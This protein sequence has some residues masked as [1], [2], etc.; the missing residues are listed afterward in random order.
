MKQIILVGM[1]SVALASGC[2]PH[3]MKKK[4]SELAYPGYLDVGA[5]Y[6]VIP[7]GAPKSQDIG[8]FT[9]TIKA[10]PGGRWYAP[11][12]PKTEE[13]K[14]EAIN[15]AAEA[16]VA[17][18]KA[19]A[20]QKEA[21]VAKATNEADATQKET[22]AGE[23]KNDATAKSNEYLLALKAIADTSIGAEL[24]QIKES[25]FA[26]RVFIFY[27]RSIGGYG[28]AVNGEVDAIGLGYDVTP[29]FALIAGQARYSVDIPAV[30]TTA[31]ST[32][33]HDGL[34]MGVQL[35]LNAFQLFRALGKTD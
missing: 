7:Y 25:S 29:E 2:T 35:N 8:G 24:Y 34:M 30:G 13:Q 5:G 32:D 15:K 23:A 6:T 31:A 22:D 27:G 20:I 4:H 9:A 1:V 17:K 19:N 3:Y 16:I 12:K 14:A 11:V 18:A 10:Y 28:S 33:T 21:D 26:K